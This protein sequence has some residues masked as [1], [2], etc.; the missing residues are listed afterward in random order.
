MTAISSEGMIETVRGKDYPNRT[1]LK[2][3]PVDVQWETLGPSLHN[4]KSQIT[5]KTVAIVLSFPY[6]IIYD[7]TKISQF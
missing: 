6:G 7:T 1:E 3:V 5:H 4:V 2:I